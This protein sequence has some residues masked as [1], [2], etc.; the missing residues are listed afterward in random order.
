MMNE[1]MGNQQATEAEI[2]WLAGIID[3]EGHVGISMQ[4]KSVSRSVS[5][6]LQI[7]NTDFALI[8]KVVSIM[9]KLDVN[10]HIRDRI[11]AKATWNSN[12][13]VSL[14]K[15]AHVK[16][17][18]DAVLPHLTGM[19]REKAQ[20]VLALIESRMT[21]TRFDKYDERELALVEDFRTSF[22]GKY[23]ASTTARETRGDFGPA[24]KIQ[25][26]LA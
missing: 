20:I 11:H 14:R 8:E 17:V 4:N 15:F 7:V 25:S 23:G 9:R 13:I 26:G 21:K 1:T 2:G 16:R 6:D 5:V 3:G 10:P 18:L 12:R 19:K 22:I 24:M